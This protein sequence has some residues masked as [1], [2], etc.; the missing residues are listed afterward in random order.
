MKLTFSLVTQPTPQTPHRE[1]RRERDHGAHRR[2]S[3]Q[4]QDNITPSTPLVLSPAPAHVKSRRAERGRDIS[5]VQPLAPTS[6]RASHQQREASAVVSAGLS[7]HPY[8]APS[9]NP[10]RSSSAIGGFGRHSP[11]AANALTNGNGLPPHSSDTYLFGQTAVKTGTNSRETTTAGTATK[12][13]AGLRGMGVYDREQMQRVGEQ[14]EDG[15]HGRR[16]GFWAALCCR[17]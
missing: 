7:P 11:N 12:D 9:T 2:A 1:H 3:R 16:H 15:G 13:V 5:S 17:A 6:R 14:D 8:A 4:L 10:Y